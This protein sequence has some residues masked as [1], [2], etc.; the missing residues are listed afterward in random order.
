MVVQ[1][2]SQGFV[3]QDCLVRRFVIFGTR[4]IHCIAWRFGGV[5]EVVLERTR[6]GFGGWYLERLS[7]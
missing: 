5:L 6:Q 7:T 3:G 2:I 4:G 1:E